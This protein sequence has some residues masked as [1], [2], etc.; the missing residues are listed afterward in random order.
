MAI[1]YLAPG[2]SPVLVDS[3][4]LA[5]KPPGLL[6][7]VCIADT[8]NEHENVALPAGD[9]LI[10]AG[11]ALTESGRRH[12]KQQLVS[13]AGAKLLD[14]FA[15]WFGAQP[16]AH[17]LVIGGNHDSVFQGLGTA[18]VRRVFAKYSA[19]SALYVEHENAQVGGLRVFG[20]PRARW[21]GAN[22]A[23]LTSEPDFS[24][25]A[26][27][28]HIVVTHM[29]PVLPS[30]HGGN[31][32]DAAVVDMLHRVGARLQVSGHC[33][34]AHGAYTTSGVGAAAVPCVVA[35]ISGEWAWP[36]NLQVG[37]SRARGDPADLWRGGYNLTHP[38][39]V[40]DIEAPVPTPEDA[41]MV[42]QPRDTAPVALAV[43]HPHVIPAASATGVL[44]A[45]AP[46][47]LKPALLLFCAPNDPGTSK[48]LEGAL[49]AHF[50]VVTI[51]SADEAVAALHER[52]SA[53]RDPRASSASTPAPC[54]P[55][56]ATGDTD[57]LPS[58]AAAQK[59]VVCISKLGVR[60]NLGSDVMRALRETHGDTCELIVHS[61]TARGN[62]ATE[63]W[64]RTEFGA[65]LVVDH[66][67]E[68]EM[69][70]VLERA[71]AAYRMSTCSRQD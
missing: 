29:P 53:G 17:K 55:I 9:L 4:A 5:P 3:S 64:L 18:A 46:V 23:F 25:V 11:D 26:A 66:M 39:V 7:V 35:S 8:H 38:V 54:T 52:E 22:D 33:H 15:S 28:T 6:R 60:G 67:S 13:D 24:G 40:A 32:E 63:T 58:N 1:L 14:R 70:P 36:M 27:G 34:W 45:C 71:R 49:R 19:G 44:D 16:H 62:T 48:R 56:A 10:H 65:S 20:S 2:L 50:D 59:F 31:R 69:M 68:A 37:P 43:A 51:D 21:G 41:W 42:L 47:P 12:V 61:K 30:S 57:V